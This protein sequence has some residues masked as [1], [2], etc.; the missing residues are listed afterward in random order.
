MS[1]GEVG[2]RAAL[3][4]SDQLPGSALLAAQSDATAPFRYLT[5]SR[6]V[7]LAPRKARIANS[8]I[9]VRS[10]A[11]RPS[12]SLLGLQNLRIHQLFKLHRSPY[13]LCRPVLLIFA[14]AQSLLV[15]VKVADIG[16]NP[17]SIPHVRYFI[18]P[19]A[20]PRVP[21]LRPRFQALLQLG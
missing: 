3:N 15:H 10:H 1:A 5:C 20:Q 2:I 11:Q 4:L 12:L 18:P 13:Q 6:T 17:P 21:L 9:L 7:A 8:Q 14:L 16:Y 19:L